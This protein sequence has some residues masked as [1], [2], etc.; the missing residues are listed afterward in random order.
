MTA[1]DAPT[2]RPTDGLTASAIHKSYG[3]VPVLRGVELSVRPGEIHALLGANGAGKSTV[4]K[5]LSGAEQP[6]SGEISVLGTT[7]TGMTPRGAREAG[8]EVIHQTPSLALTLDVADN[9]FLGREPARGPLRDRRAALRQTAE[10]LN[11]LGSDIAPDADL[12]TLSNA[13]LTVIEITKALAQNPAVLILDEPTSSLTEREV[14]QLA[15]RM[16]LLRDKG[17]PLLFVT[18]RMTEALELADRVTVLRGGQV[19]L[20]KPTSA[21]TEAEMISAIVGPRQAVSGPADRRPAPTT[22]GPAV[23]E[24]TDLDGPGIGPVD[25][26]VRPGEI[27]GVFGLVGAGRTELLET[28]AG[29]RRASRGRILLDGNRV[30]HRSPA[31]AVADGIALVPSDRL[32]KSIFATLPA[33]SNVTMGRLSATARWGVFRSR[34]TEQGMFD[35]VVSILRLSPDRGDLEAGRYSGGNQQKL[36]IGRWLNNAASVRLLLLDEPTDGVDVGA[37]ADLYTAMRTFAAGGGALLFASSEADELIAVADR[38]IVLARGRM[39][40][41][42]TGPDLTESRLLSLAHAGE[43]MS[44]PAVP[45]GPD[46]APSSTAE[47]SHAHVH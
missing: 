11:Q 19:V 26:V 41:E 25:L 13:D 3:G 15:I 7:V 21:V 10:L 4:I 6:D 22:A 33:E 40:G 44:P 35:T 47:A 17:L 23:L 30:S 16:R 27:V 24:V 9:V 1:V 39:T 20:S 29:A 34:R 8:I 46:P 31:Q 2:A 36:V 14:E 43:A 37:R 18:H 12:R 5:C 45:T 42:I 38:V 28:I 32:R